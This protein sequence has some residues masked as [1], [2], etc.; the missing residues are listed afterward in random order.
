M[1][2][3]TFMQVRLVRMAVFKWQKTTCE[4]AAVFEKYRIYEYIEELYDLFHIQ[5]DETNF[6]EIESYLETQGFRI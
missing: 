3:I 1:N 4:C 5:G 6:S 2:E